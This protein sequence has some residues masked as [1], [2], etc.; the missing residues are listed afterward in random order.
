MNTNHGNYLEHFLHREI[1]RLRHFFRI[2]FVL[3]VLLHDE[4]VVDL[5]LSPHVITRGVVMHGQYV[6]KIGRRELLRGDAQLVLQ[7]SNR[8]STSDRVTE[9]SPLHAHVILR[10]RLSFD[11]EGMAATRIR[12]VSRECDFLI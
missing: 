2:H 4:D 12:P 11:I 1:A 10:V 9:R 8:R 7:F 5:V 3:H 6:R